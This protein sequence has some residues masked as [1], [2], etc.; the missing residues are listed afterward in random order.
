MSDRAFESVNETNEPE[1]AFEPVK[2]IDLSERA[3]EPVK[4]VDLSERALESVEDIDWS[5]KAF[6]EID[7][8][9][10]KDDVWSALQSVIS[11]LPDD[12]GIVDTV[13]NALKAFTS[14]SSDCGFKFRNVVENCSHSRRILLQILLPRPFLSRTK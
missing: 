12:I 14:V 11:L 10:L 9:A 3:F 1:R 8:F 2:N 13:V 7:A 6:E 4:D 5:D